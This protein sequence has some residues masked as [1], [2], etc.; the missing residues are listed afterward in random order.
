MPRTR[1]DPDYWQNVT[2]DRI[3]NA[4]RRSGRFEKEIAEDLSITP[5]GFHYKLKRMSLT[6]E[7]FS[8]IADAADMSDQEILKIV[9]RK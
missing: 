5:Q 7:D 3:R 1:L 4:I 2:R 8:I 6:L 9:R